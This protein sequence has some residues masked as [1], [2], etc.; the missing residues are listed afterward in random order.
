MLSKDICCDR[1]YTNIQL[2]LFL[3]VITTYF[4]ILFTICKCYHYHYY[5]YYGL[6]IFY[7]KNS[8]YDGRCKFENYFISSIFITCVLIEL[9]YSTHYIL[10]ISYLISVSSKGIYIVILGCVKEHRKLPYGRSLFRVKMLM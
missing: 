8:S 4:V 1:I 5:Y 3:S 9:L 7:F 2:G 6:L 10:I